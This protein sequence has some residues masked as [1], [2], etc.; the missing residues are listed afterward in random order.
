MA[1]QTLLPRG[2]DPWA[3][4][5]NGWYFYTQT[6]IKNV[7]LWKTRDLSELRT[8]KRVVVWKPEA[9]TVCSKN[10]WAPELHRLDGRWY[11]YFA[12]DD[13]HNR[14]HRLY[15]LVSDADDPTSKNWQFAGE[16]KTPDSRWA[17]DATILRYNR[18]LHLLWSGWEGAENGQQNI[19]IARMKD[20][21]NVEGE[22]VLISKP[23]HPWE[24]HGTIRN[25]KQDDKPFVAV[26]EGPA[27]L[28]RD[29]RVLVTYSASGSWTKYYCVGMLWAE[30]GTDLLNPGSW[31]KSK[32]PVF[33]AVDAGA[34]GTVAAGH[35]SFFRCPDYR[36]DWI[37]Y[38]A[39]D[40][41]GLGWGNRSPRAQRFE[42]NAAGF[43]VFGDPLAIH[44][45]KDVSA[46]VNRTDTSAT[47]HRSFREDASD[48]GSYGD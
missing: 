38:H 4:R 41:L 17:I 34:Q 33:T 18:R 45:L 47:V 2:A 39:N 7:T 13:G 9:G 48:A 20:P 35:N 14:N 12:A 3:I 28:V 11:I 23:E 19:Y 43:P 31:R 46:A 16:L 15:V 5:H 30:A 29:G 24:L 44:A 6:T 32:T 42:W 1:G 21:L 22:R 37:L 27:A 36:E 25:P 8:A 10:I 40:R 26:N